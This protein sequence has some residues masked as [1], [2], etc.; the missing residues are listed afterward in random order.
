MHLDSL[1]TH[2]QL[3]NAGFTPPVANYSRPDPRGAEYGTY[4][5]RAGTHVIT[6]EY[7]SG[8]DRK[9]GFLMS[10]TSLGNFLHWC[11]NTF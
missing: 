3:V 11:R 2:E 8:A 9:C 5:V 7:V 10:F 6:V 4:L 1:V